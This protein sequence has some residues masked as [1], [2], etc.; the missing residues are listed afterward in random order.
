MLVLSRK[1]GERV[2]IGGNIVLTVV[3][4]RPDRIRLGFD[5]PAEITVH[6]EEV[7]ERIRN[8]QI[9]APAHAAADE[10]PFHAEFA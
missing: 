8:E 2:C 4:I 9:A 1:L 3:D 10:S 6:R 7:N 5:C